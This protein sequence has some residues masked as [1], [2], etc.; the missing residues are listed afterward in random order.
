MAPP[1]AARH[2]ESPGGSDFA[3]GWPIRWA[4][5]GWLD[6]CRQSVFGES[7]VSIQHMVG[8]QAGTGLWREFARGLLQ[9][10]HDAFVFLVGCTAV[11]LAR[12]VL[13]PRE[14]EFLDCLLYTSPSPRD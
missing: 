12:Q 13:E 2:E 8:K 3:C 9:C 6:G 11:I 4:R 1:G 7:S 14:V 10:T 5:S